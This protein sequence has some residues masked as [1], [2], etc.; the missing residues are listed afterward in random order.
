MIKLMVTKGETRD[1]VINKEIENDIYI[2]L[3]KQQLTNKDLLY[4]KM[5]STQYSVI[6]HMKRETEKEWRY[7]YIYIYN[8]L[9]CV[10]EINTAI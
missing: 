7:I 2:L 3:Y 5:N 4:S 8:S 10:L 1:E 9:C 6:N